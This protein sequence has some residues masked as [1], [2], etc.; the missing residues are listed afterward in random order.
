MQFDAKY[1]ELAAQ[2]WKR[3]GSSKSGVEPPCRCPFP[4]RD[5]ESPEPGSI[6]VGSLPTEANREWFKENRV[7]LVVT[8]FAESAITREV[9]EQGRM[10][11]GWIPDSCYVVHVMVGCEKEP[12][13]PTCTLSTPR[14]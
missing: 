4:P 1:D 7:T 14:I 3:K 8:C 6:W 12:Q 10:V 13:S 5:P 2:R 9:R 11:K